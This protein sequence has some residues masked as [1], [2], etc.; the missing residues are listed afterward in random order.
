MNRIRNSTL[1]GLH[2]AIIM[3]GNG[4]W[5]RSRG[6]P[7]T[8]GPRAGSDAVRRTVEACPDSGVTTL[9]LY[10]F[11][12]DNWQRPAGEVAT[13]MRLFHRYLIQERQRAIREASSFALLRCSP[14]ST[15]NSTKPMRY[16][17]EASMLSPVSAILRA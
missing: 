15:R 2:V 4:R 6:R 10:A 7:R 16:A 12:C 8:A 11:S 3:D 13:L 17:S 5:A 14:S 9:T 1:Q